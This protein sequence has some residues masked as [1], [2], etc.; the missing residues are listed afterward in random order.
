MKNHIKASTD[1]IPFEHTLASRGVLYLP[2][3]ANVPNRRTLD[4]SWSEGCS[5]RDLTP[6]KKGRGARAEYAT[7]RQCN[8]VFPKLP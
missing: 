1:L 7:T 3:K 6:E 2:A 4:R 5:L 8:Y